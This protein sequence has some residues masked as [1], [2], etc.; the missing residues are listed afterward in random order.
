MDRTGCLFDCSDAR[1]HDARLVS[2]SESSDEFWEYLKG[3]HQCLRDYRR[4]NPTNPDTRVKIAILDSGADLSHPII[5]HII[6]QIEDFNPEPVVFHSF[7]DLDDTCPDPLGHGTH[8]T[9]TILS[10]ANGA[11]L[12]VGRIVGKDKM[13]D[14][15]ALAEA[16]NYAVDTW[17]V[18][19]ISLSLGF[20]RPSKDL[21]HSIQNALH[22]EKLIFAAVSNSGGALPTG[23]SWPARETKVFGVFSSNFQGERSTFNPNVNDDDTFSRYKFLG[24][25]VN[26]AWLNCE[27][28]R[29]T[30]TSVA[31][32]IAASTAALFLEYIRGNMVGIHDISL[33][34]E[35]E[36]C[37]SMPDGMRRIF[38]LAG[39]TR[40]TH[41]FLRYVTPWSLLDHKNQRFIMTRID[42][43]LLDLQLIYYD[44][45]FAS[46]EKDSGSI[47]TSLSDQKKRLDSN[48]KSFEKAKS[49]LKTHVLSILGVTVLGAGSVDV[50]FPLA[51]WVTGSLALGAIWWLLSSARDTQGTI[52][53]DFKKRA[54][55]VQP[56]IN[57]AIK[58]SAKNKSEGD[59]V[60]DQ[61]FKLLA[62]I[63][64][65]HKSHA[66]V[67]EPDSHQLED[68]LMQLKLR[69]KLH[70][71][72]ETELQSALSPSQNA[73]VQDLMV[74]LEKLVTEGAGKGLFG[75][76]AEHNELAKSAKEVLDRAIRAALA[77]HQAQ[78]EVD[79]VSKEIK[80]QT[81]K[82]SA[83]LAEK[84]E[85]ET[86]GTLSWLHWFLLWLGITGV[87]L[88]LILAVV[89]AS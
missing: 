66:Q 11:K 30:G 46:L 38:A 1:L 50:A 37:A 43:C 19:I 51:K 15:E 18:D 63:I 21:A 7:V 56:K 59:M 9:S 73:R 23:I 82:A 42:Q 69:L 2:E 5:V 87:A 55:D 31:T 36:R 13:V 41:D 80:S 74:K 58:L 32:P 68:K 8:I 64:E 57:E 6:D 60:L 78:I 75:E 81:L 71:I 79:E 67:S 12:Y 85:K 17:E 34:A 54:T 33:M 70:I 88:T 84:R 14:P 4:Y 52:L 22:K 44:K 16:I 89:A 86:G 77:V 61:L 35:I 53:T 47:R 83:D 10:I 3:A 24:E 76:E 72:K 27:E 40:E 29:M 20:P 48:Q 65:H 45:K 49:E 28:K 25:A 62:R 26:S 39:T